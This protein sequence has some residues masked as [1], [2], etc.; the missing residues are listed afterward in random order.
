[1][2]LTQ[3]NLAAQGDQSCADELK[4]ICTLR[5]S[6]HMNPGGV[7][8]TAQW[9]DLAMLNYAVDPALLQKFVP[10]GTE[11]DRWD[12]NALVSLV[13]F[14]FLNTKVFGI[15]FPFHS[16]FE[17]VNLRLYVQRRE[18]NLVKRGVVFIRE[19][20]PR[21]TISTVARSLYNE[22]Y[23]SLP[24]SHRIHSSDGG[25]SVSYSWKSRT[26]WNKISLTAKGDPVLP[27]IG[28]EEQFIT[29][30]YWGY[31]T[32]RDGGCVEYRV[33]HPSWRVWAA[34]DA[35]FEG[36]MKDLYG[37][38]LAAVLEKPPMSAFLAEGSDVTVYRGRRL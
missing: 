8:I 6:K 28:S 37:K 11:L 29:E 3:P 25:I 16:N 19:I 27:E 2:M 24:M 26:R 31:A 35:R 22:N 34:P 36:D 23:V 5:I 7:F 15:S 32:Q 1:M 10:A 21:W 30:H 20:V 17:E 13:G 4:R 14:R 18:G 12:G 38:D 33:D 9:R